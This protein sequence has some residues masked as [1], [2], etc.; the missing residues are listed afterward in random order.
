MRRPW[1]DSLFGR[2]ALVL[3]AGLILA[4]VGS[5][6]I[7]A[8]ERNHLLRQFDEQ[9]WRERMAA[10]VKLLDALAP[11]ERPPA[12]AAL[13]ARR[14]S[15]EIAVQPPPARTQEASDMAGQ[16][17]SL[18]GPGYRVRAWREH[19]VIRIAV[20]LHDGHWLILDHDPSVSAF[21]WPLQ[22]LWN[23]T[24]LLAATLGLTLL[25]TRAAL[26]PLERFTRAA[27]RLGENL[28]APPIAESGAREVRRAART[29]NR[30]QARIRESVAERTRLLAAISHDLKTPL[31]RLRL[32][33]EFIREDPELR[34][35]LLREVETMQTMT[36]AVI[37]VLRG[38]EGEEV[39]NVDVNA[40]VEGLAAD[41]MELGA[42]V[43]IHGRAHAPYPGRSL[44]LRRALGNLLD[45]A[46]QYAGGA[47]EIAV[48]D[49]AAALTIRVTD[50]GPGIPEAEQVRMIEPFQR[51]EPS[52][53]P[54]T[55]GSGLGLA[56]A[57]SIARAHGG[58]LSL[59]N[60]P[61]GGLEIQI[62]LPREA[63]S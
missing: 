16:L 54:A 13:A 29:L 46:R 35:T 3:L 49:D 58:E 59:Q 30:M 1:P 60:R 40:L 15:I 18:L 45:N 52:R 6:L 25:A 21:G 51:L 22:L 34:A 50:R 37:D 23:L 32:R 57:R 47:I 61:G 42:R 41:A 43:T 55:G 12:L 38:G 26:G 2:I 24:V 11:A 10:T 44:A 56:I 28:D 20:E 27:E 17:V 9:R 14:L 19:E 53:N 7:N 63:T 33:A 5:A 4:Q 48:E 8:R 39:R 62:R 36:R 31:T